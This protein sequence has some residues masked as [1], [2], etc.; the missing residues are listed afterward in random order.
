[1]NNS[2]YDGKD[3]KKLFNFQF[4][5]YNEPVRNVY[6]AKYD[7]MQLPEGLN[8]LAEVKDNLDVVSNPDDDIS[9][10]GFLVVKAPLNEKDLEELND[11]DDLLGDLDPHT[12]SQPT[13]R[14]ATTAIIA[15]ESQKVEI[16]TQDDLKELDDLMDEYIALQ[17]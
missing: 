12:L 2:R 16:V 3:R 9:D 4:T 17:T 5:R 7:Y 8:E 11:L 15:T 13:K 10:D 1:M 6:L 14:T